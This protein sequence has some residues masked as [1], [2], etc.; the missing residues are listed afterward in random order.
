MA[1]RLAEPG[2]TGL[3]QSIAGT[4][5]GVIMGTV[6]YMSPEQALGQPV[7]ARSDLFSF[8]VAL[9][10]AAAG[11]LPFA[12]ATTT[13]VFD[14]ILHQP[15]EPLASVL[16]PIILKLLEKDPND[17]YQSAR[18]VLVD[19]RRLKRAW[20]TGKLA[21][22]RRPVAASPRRHWRW[23]AALVLTFA[24]GAV[25]ERY[26]L[27][28]PVA[29][30]AMRFTAVTNFAGVESHPTF[31][32]DG[33]SVAFVSDRGGQSDLWVSLVSAG[34]LVRITN[35]PNLKTRPRW[36]P[37]G[38][39]IAY[40][41]LNGS[42]LWDIWVVPALG[43]TPRRILPEATDPAWSPEGRRLAYA[44]RA[45]N[46]IWMSDAIGGNARAV[47]QP[48][49]GL[50]H[51]QPAFSRDGR[52]I[53]FV[54]RMTGPYGELVLVDAHVG[55][56]LGPVQLVLRVDNLL[57]YHNVLVEREIQPLRQWSLASSG[58]L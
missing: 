43:G 54:R 55:R 37:D 5:T 29:R 39:R 27:N 36:S 34:S 58:V 48:E 26:L 11:R 14:N 40:G 9:Y 41:R 28:R 23:A 19:L 32:P 47:T 17:R 25:V 44:N 52:Q 2:E 35:D 38:A 10:E 31:S 57:Q 24:A 51:A 7:D 20:D 50:L 4:E 8:G 3:T 53:A 46:G 15:P 56:Q 49:A 30:P 18:E 21:S 16:E 22:A 12:G 1:K 13:A 42:G 33:G 45:T 6:S